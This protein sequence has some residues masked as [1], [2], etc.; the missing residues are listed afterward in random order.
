MA[1]WGMGSWFGGGAAKRSDAP[2]KAILQLREQL[3][4]LNKREKHLENQ[5]NEQDTLA[6]K[7]VAS[8]KNGT[9]SLSDDRIRD[10]D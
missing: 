7:H 3:E 4:M 8:N 6:R 1:G 2:K 9:F 5:M 10:K